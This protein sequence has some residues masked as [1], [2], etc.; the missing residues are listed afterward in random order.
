MSSEN[1]SDQNGN[2]APPAAS[3]SPPSGTP[4]KK[5]LQDS[6]ELTPQIQWHDGMPLSPHHF[7][8]QDFRSQQVLA[9][10]LRA[11]SKYHYGVSNLQIDAVSLTT[12]VFRVLKAA[13]V[14]PDTLVYNYDSARDSFTLELDLSPFEAQLADKADWIQITIAEHCKGVSPVLGASPRFNSH[15]GGDVY[16]ENTNDNPISIPRLLPNFLLQFGGVIPS[17]CVGFPIAAVKFED[18]V[19]KLLEYTPPCFLLS[20]DSPILQRSAVVAKKIR[21]KVHVFSEKMHNQVGSNLLRETAD[22]L[23]PLISV[24]PILE[25]VLSDS[26]PPYFLYCEL[27][28]IAG[29]IAQLVLFQVP[30]KFAPYNHNRIDESIEQILEYIIRNIDR[31]SVEYTV[32]PFIKNDKIFSLKL[33]KAYFASNEENKGESSKLL[34]GV[35]TRAGTT[36]N[37]IGEWMLGAVVASD[38]ALAQVKGKRVLGAPR[39]I[40]SDERLYKLSPPRD[41][42]IFSVDVENDYVVRDQY[43]HIFN[44]SDTEEN[45]PLDIVL[46]VPKH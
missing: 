38:G 2:S 31:L 23:R 24:L 11:L 34:V 46:Y 14:M 1:I 9:H 20:E 17:K 21:E 7:Q 10:H 36:Y 22:I 37:Q 12:G 6:V 13:I 28:R 32:F 29:T 35:K 15:E 44:Q 8:Q 19:F 41:I 25:V 18:G 16:D 5:I 42:T 45:R 43:L 33:H 26:V 39:T 4:P 3:S 40:V 27:V 30:K